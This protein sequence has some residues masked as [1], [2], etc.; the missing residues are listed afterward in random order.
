[1]KLHY[2]PIRSK[3]SQGVPDELLGWSDVGLD[4]IHQ[5]IYSVVVPDSNENCQKKKDQ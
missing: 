4:G 3:E 1:M 2:T 5:D